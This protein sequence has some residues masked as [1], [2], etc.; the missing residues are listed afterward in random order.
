MESKPLIGI[1]M[2]IEL[3]TERFYL[4]RHYSEAVAAAGGIPVHIAL[5]ATEQYMGEVLP[6]LDGILLPGSDT[7]C[8]PILYGE[9]P[10][11]KLGRVVPEKDSNDRLILDHVEATAKPFMGICFGMQ[12]LNVHRGGSLIQDINSQAPGSLRHEQGF[13]RDVQSHGIKIDSDSMLASIAGG[14]SARVN[15]HHH[16]AVKEIGRDLRISARASD[17]IIEAVEDTRPGRF[18]LGVQWHPELA[19]N[20]D[21]LSTALFR[22]FVSECNKAKGASN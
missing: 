20:R 1:A 3:E 21:Q 2:R 22:R 17:G 14:E 8:D 11:P 12:A 6:R 13:P 10:H 9:E 15:S 18:V 19:W 5:I 16:Q 7:D 4:A